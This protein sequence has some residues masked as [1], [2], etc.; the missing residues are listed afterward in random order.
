MR[1]TIAHVPAK[2][3]VRKKKRIEKD[4]SDYTKLKKPARPRPRPRP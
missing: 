1:I 4:L 3:P 2:A